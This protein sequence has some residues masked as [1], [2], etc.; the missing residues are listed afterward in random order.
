MS[1]PC[2]LTSYFVNPSSRHQRR[3]VFLSSIHRESILLQASMGLPAQSQAQEARTSPRELGPGSLGRGGR[4]LAFVPGILRLPASPAQGQNPGS[5]SA[6]HR[7]PEP[8][9]PQEA[10]SP[11]A[12]YWGSN[13]AP[14]GA[15]TLVLLTWDSLKIQAC[16]ELWCGY[17][18][19]E[20]MIPRDYTPTLCPIS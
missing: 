14:L 19:S 20:A 11:S 17:C 16:K 5:S 1:D 4:L 12:L 7:G 15:P 13:C 3:E 18:W 10:G 8:Q 6:I 2:L 9:H